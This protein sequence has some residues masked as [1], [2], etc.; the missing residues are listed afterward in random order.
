M[1]LSREPSFSYLASYTDTHSHGGGDVIPI[2]EP[3]LIFSAQFGSFWRGIRHVLISS[4]QNR[5][6]RPTRGR[7]RRRGRVRR[8]E[9]AGGK[10]PDDRL[11]LIGRYRA[12][13]HPV[14]LRGGV[15]QGGLQLVSRRRANCVHDERVGR[16]ASRRRL[17]LLKEVVARP[18]PAVASHEWS[19]SASR[20]RFQF[21][22]SRRRRGVR[23]PSGSSNH[24]WP[25][26]SPFSASNGGH[27][28]AD[29]K[30]PPDDHPFERSVVTVRVEARERFDP[31]PP[32]QCES[33]EK[34]TRCSQSC[35]GPE[36]YPNR[37][38]H[39]APLFTLKSARVASLTPA[40]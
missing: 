6:G 15:C 1:G 33:S 36:T 21:V 16:R 5:R 27:N 4:L 24:R 17:Q 3:L 20:A 39:T 32:N 28:D 10:R 22:D 29:E 18:T 30:E 26:T 14:L 35:L 7:G 37:R 2:V 13:K 19:R 25:A 23:K 9:H 38:L 11:D 8:R 40:R 34:P 31:V 12:E